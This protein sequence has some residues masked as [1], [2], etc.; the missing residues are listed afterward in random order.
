MYK[1]AIAIVASWLISLSFRAE[2][3]YLTA[4]DLYRICTTPAERILCIGYVE[5]VLDV[6]DFEGLYYRGR[7]NLH[8]FGQGF[9]ER[10]PYVAEWCMPL[11]ITSGRATD[12]TIKFIRDNPAILQERA[13]SVL[14]ASMVREWPCPR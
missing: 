14:V 5:G 12:V 4:G 9:D 7:F 11:A 3:G 1:F 6:A 10:H 8:W 2:A 13:S